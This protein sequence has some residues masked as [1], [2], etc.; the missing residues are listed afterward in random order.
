MRSYKKPP[1]LVVFLW[2]GTLLTVSALSLWRLN[3]EILFKPARIAAT[4][5]GLKIQNFKPRFGIMIP[6]GF[7]P[8][9]ANTEYLFAFS[10]E[11]CDGLSRVCFTILLGDMKRTIPAANHREDEIR[12]GILSEIKKD[13]PS[14]NPDI[15]FENIKVLGQRMPM[16]IVRNIDHSGMP[17]TTF[18][19]EIP[20]KDSAIVVMVLGPAN[21]ESGSRLLLQNIL[22]SL[23]T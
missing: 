16:H 18:G 1:S 21:Q 14:A 9:S 4:S 22:R 11:N 12:R 20:L 7:I 3:S 5:Q 19:V 10:E 13:F 15:R 6:K 2:F 23:Q 17:V 8:I